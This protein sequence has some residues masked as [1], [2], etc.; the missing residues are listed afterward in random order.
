MNVVLHALNSRYSEGVQDPCE[1][2]G[3]VLA[4][5][6]KSLG[7]NLHT[8]SDQKYQVSGHKPIDSVT[9]NNYSLLK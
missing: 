7:F 3:T 8:L 6:V 2:K 1:L 9:T 4:Y 5:Q